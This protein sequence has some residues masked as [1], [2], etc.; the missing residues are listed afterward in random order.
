MLGTAMTAGRPTSTAREGRTGL[1]NLDR[2]KGLRNLYKPSMKAG[3]GCIAMYN[4]G[5]SPRAV[6]GPRQAPP[7]CPGPAAVLRLRESGRIQWNR[8]EPTGVG[9]CNQRIPFQLRSGRN[10]KRFLTVSGGFCRPHPR[11]WRADEQAGQRLS[12]AAPSTAMRD[13]LG[14]PELSAPPKQS[15]AADG[16]AWRAPSR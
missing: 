4:E 3:G 14:L 10:Q 5:D 13:V 12:G 9:G 16:G 2:R 1:R 11:V 7:R 6:R 8:L 15:T